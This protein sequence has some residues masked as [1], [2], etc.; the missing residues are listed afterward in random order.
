MPELCGSIRK[1]RRWIPLTRVKS[2]KKWIASILLW[3]FRKYGDRILLD[4]SDRNPKSKK[5]TKKSSSVPECKQNTLEVVESQHGH[6]PWDPSLGGDGFPKFLCDLMVEGLAKHLRC[7]GVDATFPY[8]KRPDA[9]DS[10][11]Q[12]LKEKRVLLTRDP[13]LFRHE[14]LIE[15]QL[16]K[17]KSVLRNERPLEVIETFQL[18][19]SE[20]QLVS[21]CTKCNGRFI[22]KLSGHPKDFK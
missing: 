4:D 10:I 22:Q 3:I 7:V 8:S 5:K 20:D 16:Y 19:I 18:K 11:D 15:N 2:T 13:K 17:V 12:A 1:L 6:P 14:Y 21:R 9:R